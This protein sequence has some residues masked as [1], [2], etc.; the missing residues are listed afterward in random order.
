MGIA[1]AVLEELQQRGCMFL[2]T[3]HYPQVKAYAEKT[4]GI[5][6]ARMA[7]DR[8]SLSPL[9]QLEM[10]KS[11]ESCALHIAGRLGLA[12]HLLERARY[13]VYGEAGTSFTA[14][15]TAMPTPKSRLKRREP[16]KQAADIGGKFSMGDSV[17]VLPGEEIGVVYRPADQ[18]GE[19][20]VQVKGVKR[21][22]KHT[23]LRLLVPASELYPPDYDFS[24][25]FDTVTNRK[26]RH[27]MGKRHDANLSITYTD[28]EHGID[29]N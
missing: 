4:G 28:A 27:Q 23:R 21:T 6:S 8:E 12:P 13:E 14:E 29:Y 10:G 16:P 11:G 25:I 3:T 9:Y 7:F 20:I 2:V 15:Q 5:K 17:A 22:V 1:V 24:I 26:A 19:V 18:N